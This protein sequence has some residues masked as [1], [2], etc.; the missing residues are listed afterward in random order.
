MSEP[1]VVNSKNEVFDKG[2]SF[3]KDRLDLRGVDIAKEWRLLLNWNEIDQGVQKCADVINKKFEGKEII[4]VCVLKGGVYFFV[5]LVRKLK[6]PYSTDF[7]KVKS[8]G[9]EKT[10]QESIEL[11][12]PID[13]EMYRDKHMIIVDEIY[14]SG[15]TLTQLKLILNK[16]TGIPLE[17]FFTCT[18]LKKDRP[19]IIDGKSRLDL[20]KGDITTFPD[21]YAYLVPNYWLTGYG[22]D[23]KQEKG[24]WTCIFARNC[25]PA[26]EISMFNNN[27]EYDKV[28]KIVLGSL[29]EKND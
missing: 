1:I 20:P 10:Q 7:L 6:I 27:K 19:D 14:D 13:P 23:D 3:L 17:N 8:Y 16:K 12:S 2:E 26:K 24:G 29:Y 9:N 11:L 25:G 18:L 4:V 22:L 21:L 5:D 15:K 28:R